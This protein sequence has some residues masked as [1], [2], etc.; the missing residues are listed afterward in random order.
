MRGVDG[1]MGGDLLQ[2]ACLKASISA[3]DSNDHRPPSPHTMNDGQDTDR[4]R[5]TSV[6][7]GSSLDACTSTGAGNSLLGKSGV[8]TWSRE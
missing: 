8:T 4:R 3:H 1:V 6:P 2:T 7:T 5:R